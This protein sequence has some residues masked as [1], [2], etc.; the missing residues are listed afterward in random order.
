MPNENN[1]TTAA[2]D[3]KEIELSAPRARGTGRIFTREGTNSLWIQYSRDGRGIVS[4]RI[5]QM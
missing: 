1:K 3:E 5:R 2:K 4:R